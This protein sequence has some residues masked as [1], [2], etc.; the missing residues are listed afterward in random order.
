MNLFYFCCWWCTPIFE[1]FRFS[2]V[3]I[4]YSIAKCLNDE[5]RCL[6]IF[7]FEKWIWRDENGIMLRNLLIFYVIILRITL[8]RSHVDMYRRKCVLVSQC[9]WLYCYYTLV[10]SHIFSLPKNLHYCP[11][12]ILLFPWEYQNECRF[13]TGKSNGNFNWKCEPSELKI[14]V[15]IDITHIH[16]TRAVVCYVT[17]F[18]I[19]IDFSVL[20]PHCNHKIRLGGKS[21]KLNRINV[22]DTRRCNLKTNLLPYPWMAT[23]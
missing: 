22:L 7:H 2:I 13:E 14:L 6:F 12:F 11:F 8:C 17:K 5:W 18:Q 20:L 1:N 10:Y 15:L 3:D 19:S 23:K 9:H 4:D 21:H 16:T